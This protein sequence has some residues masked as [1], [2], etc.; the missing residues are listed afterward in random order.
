MAE[1]ALKIVEENPYEKRTI[2]DLILQRKKHD[3]ERAAAS[4]QERQSKAQIAL[5]DEVLLAF[6]ETS[7]EVAI[8]QEGGTRIGFTEETI[9]NASGEVKQAFSEWVRE[10]GN[11]H[12]ITW[13]I[14]NAAA[15]EHL[16]LYGELPHAEPFK[17]TK[18]SMTTAK[19]KKK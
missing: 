4:R 3:E 13:H 14:N 6:H 19:A 2:A 17:K 5:I 7:P 16:A 10:T 9:F 8:L 12:L 18:V 11:M 15:R 1:A